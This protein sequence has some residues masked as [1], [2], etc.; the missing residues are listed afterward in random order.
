MDQPPPRRPCVFAVRSGRHGRSNPRWRDQRE[1]CTPKA[2]TTQ[3]VSQ[4]ETE[5][6]A[7]LWRWGHDRS[8]EALRPLRQRRH[9]APILSIVSSV[10]TGDSGAARLLHEHDGLGVAT[11]EADVP[12]ARCSTPTDGGGETSDPRSAGEPLFVLPKAP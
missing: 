10:G 8:D 12:S 5:N 3:F 11:N 1:P 2:A 6:S 7:T 4:T 9:S